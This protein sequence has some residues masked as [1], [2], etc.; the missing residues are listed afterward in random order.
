[1][2]GHEQVATEIDMHA[3]W[4][5]DVTDTIF[6]GETSAGNEPGMTAIIVRRTT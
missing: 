4:R 6:N 2:V 5:D 3:R 1:M